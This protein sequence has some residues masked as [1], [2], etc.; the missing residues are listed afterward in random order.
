MSKRIGIF[1]GTFDPIHKGH[2]S[3]AIQAIETAGLDQV[4]FLPETR[5]RHKHDVSHFSHRVAMISVAIKA[6]PKLGVLELPDKQFTVATSLP[7]LI[8]QFPD[9]QLVMLVGSDVVSHMSV[10]PHIRTLL[11]TVG[12]VIA[13]RGEKDERQTFQ[14]LAN[15]PVEPIESHVFVSNFKAISSRDIRD[16]LK[17]GD[18]PEGMLSSVKLYATAHW[19]YSSIPR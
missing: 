14:L 9:A 12:L 1:S 11:K 15:L 10:W 16:A 19:L 2:I 5:P 3:F 4:L 7:R 6:Y 17:H 8:Q 13:A 18:A